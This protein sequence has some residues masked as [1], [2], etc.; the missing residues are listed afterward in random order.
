MSDV[1]VAKMSWQIA[2]IVFI[3][4][5]NKIQKMAKYSVQEKSDT[6]P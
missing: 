6:A 4:F 2:S 1:S 3:W 5:Y